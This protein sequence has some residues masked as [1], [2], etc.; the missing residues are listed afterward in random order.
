VE[1]SAADLLMDAEGFR[2]DRAFGSG[3]AG[4]YL[5]R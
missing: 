3:I 1:L 4:F 5:V 2:L